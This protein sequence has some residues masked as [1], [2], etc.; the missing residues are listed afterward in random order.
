MS[1]TEIDRLHSFR[2]TGKFI[3]SKEEFQQA[4]LI[5]DSLLNAISPYFK[6]PEWKVRSKEGDAEKRQSEA[7]VAIGVAV[8]RADLNK[9]KAD[10]LMRINGVG[11]ILSARILKFRKALGGFLSD[12]QLYDVYGLDPDVVRRVLKE[13]TVISRPEIQPI[14]LRTTNADELSGLVYI[15]PNLAWRIIRYRDSVGE[16]KSLEELTKLKDFPS[17]RINRIKLY[18]TL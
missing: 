12:D 3:N 17:D 7:T 6:F 16:L 18:L 11:E 15:S 8:A 5:S 4:T 10:D 2:E 14:S 13:F 1:P 9:V